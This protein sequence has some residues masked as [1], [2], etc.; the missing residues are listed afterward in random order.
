MASPVT[1]YRPVGP[2]ELEYIRASGWRR[3]P[4]RLTHQPSFY[5]VALEAHARHIAREWNV[6]ASGAGYVTR[7]EV[8]ADFLA[9]SPCL[10]ERWAP[11]EDLEAF[12]AHLVGC[13]EVVAAFP[14]A[15]A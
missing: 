14:E 4:P 2:A 10:S 8:D 1:L 7:F 3:F 5:P 13:I 15:E 9:R 12:N 6:G 11:A